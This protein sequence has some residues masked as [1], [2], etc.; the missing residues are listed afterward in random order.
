[1]SA[2]I[3]RAVDRAMLATASRGWLLACFVAMGSSLSAQTPCVNGFAG[4][5]PCDH[6]D[7]LS[8]MTI[9]QLGGQTNLAD[10]WGWTDPLT[11]TEFALVGMRTGTA[12]VDL[13][14][15]VLPVLTGVLPSHVAGANTLWRDVDVIGHHAYV[16]SETSGHGMQVFNLERLRTVVS[17]PQTFT[18][19]AHY[20]GFSNCHTLFGDDDGFVFGVGTNTASG[21]LHVVNVQNP[22]V[23][24]LSGTY[25]LDGYIHENL[26]IDYH[27]PDTEHVG[28]DI[29]IN[30][31]SGSPDKITIVD[32]SDKTDMSRLSTTTYTGSR[33]THQGWV[34]DDHRYLLM[35]DEGDEIN[36][37]HTTRTRVFDISN[38]DV[39]A[40]LVGFY[41]GP[42]ASTDHNLYVH[43]DLVW[44][45]N[46]SSGLRIL[47]P[48]DIGTAQLTQ[49]GFF[50]T[51]TTNNA[52]NYDGAWGNYPY[53][54]SGIVLVTDYANGLFILRPRPG[55]RVK[56]FLQ[57]PFDTGTGLMQDSLRQQG[58]L[59]LQ[60]P[61]TA[62]GYVHVGGGGGETTTA[63]VLA[64]TGSNAIVDWVVLELRDAAD[65]TV[66]KESRCA[67]IQRDG[68]IVATDGL[69]PVRFAQAVG[70]YHLALRHR[71]HL[72]VMTAAPVRVSLAVKDLDLSDGSIALFGTAATTQVGSVEV[73]WMGNALSDDALKYVGAENDRD[74][75]LLR[76]GS[77][78]PN[79][80]VAGYWPE[81]LN[82]DG[83]VRYTGQGNDRDAILLN[84]GSTVP[85][86]I[87]LE[88][89][90]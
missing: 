88:Q 30:F 14:N 90:P 78:S 80:I 44:E 50:D 7:L 25:T 20:A 22:L 89:I 57:G 71:N 49:V 68:D 59:P 37:A 52:A 56:A 42:N 32:V 58:L 70:D 11:G 64:A 41:A 67:L 28:K 9:T 31:H 4:I 40:P 19:D 8:R 18:E 84:I 24:V 12:F 69:S 10:L 26:V 29:S 48:V 17:P 43:K 81:D 21:G 1:M 72:G 13:S 54:K 45:A 79:S 73:L 23:P 5:Y 63:P 27:G 65:P 38:L 15:P 55:I 16:V 2:A 62:A 87:R 85:S 34:T 47:D 66:V 76:I 33:I 74:P 51:Y 36:L 82:M 39:P 46:Y 35:N 61:Y 86:N 3:A 53:F 83:Y 75:I 6:V 77:T 60:E